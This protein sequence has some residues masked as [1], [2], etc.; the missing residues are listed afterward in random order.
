MENTNPQEKI[1]ERN[2][3]FR[4]SAEVAERAAREVSRA[5]TSEGWVEFLVNYTDR[6]ELRIEIEGADEAPVP[7]Q[8]VEEDVEAEVVIVGEEDR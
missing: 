8:I 2:E 4:V 7:V 6:S 3:T 1:G 5:G